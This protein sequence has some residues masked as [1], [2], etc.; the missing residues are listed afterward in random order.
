MLTID[1]ARRFCSLRL[2]R[3]VLVLLLTLRWPP[4]WRPF[5]FCRSPLVLRCGWLVL[6]VRPR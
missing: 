5:F 2:G 1:P 3:V 4:G 6:T